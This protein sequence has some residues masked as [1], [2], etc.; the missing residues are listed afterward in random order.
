MEATKRIV[1][2][3]NIQVL[4]QDI[5]AKEIVNKRGKIEPY[6]LDELISKFPLIADFKAVQEKNVWCSE[7]YVFQQSL[8]AADRIRELHSIITGEADPEMTFIY[9]LEEK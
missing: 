8:G 4:F 7:K 1:E 3:M 2:N 9:R 5:I 6:G